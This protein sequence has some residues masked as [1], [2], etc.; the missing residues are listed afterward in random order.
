[1]DSLEVDVYSE[2]HEAEGDKKASYDVSITADMF[3]NNATL[4][5]WVGG[6]VITELAPKMSHDD[7]R[8]T[9]E[10]LVKKAYTQGIRD[11]LMLAKVSINALDD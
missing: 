8:D 4:S 11:G 10:S 1:M 7:I 6:S 9:V 3:S 5:S 2:Y